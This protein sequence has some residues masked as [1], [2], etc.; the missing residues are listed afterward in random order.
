MIIRPKSIVQP[1][2]SNDV[3]TPGTWKDY[4]IGSWAQ[5]DVWYY[6]NNDHYTSGKYF[7]AIVFRDSPNRYRYYKF[8][9]TIRQMADDLTVDII[10]YY[11]SLALENQEQWR[12]EFD[13]QEQI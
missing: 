2:Y 11:L 13:S 10:T 6:I 1:R 8:G 7:E 4:Y 9:D 5:Y 12:K 3:W